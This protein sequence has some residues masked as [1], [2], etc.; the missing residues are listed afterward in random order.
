M[1]E[2]QFLD[3]R[4]LADRWHLAVGTLSNWRSQGVGPRYTKIGRRVVYPMAE[5]ER[6]EQEHL[7]FR[8]QGD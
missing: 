5:V 2:Q 6:F 7:Q 4:Q 3:A 8:G 1:D